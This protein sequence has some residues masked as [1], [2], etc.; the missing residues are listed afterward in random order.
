MKNLSK[1]PH[2]LTKLCCLTWAEKWLLLKVLVVLATYKALLVFFPFSRFITAHPLSTPQK[3][4]LCD[5]YITEQIWAVRVISARIPLGFTCLVQA[6]GT[7]WLLNDHPDVRVCVGVRN[8]K[9]EGFSAHA[10]VTHQNKII[11]GGQTDL[12]F[13]PILVWN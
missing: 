8:R 3:K 13:E 6:L 1:P 2:N 4:A 12:V 5:S 9:I 7:K 11:L 10:W